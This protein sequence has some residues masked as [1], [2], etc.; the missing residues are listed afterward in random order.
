MATEK[1]TILIIG[2]NA[3]RAIAKTNLRNFARD[4]C[5]ENQKPIPGYLQDN[6]QNALPLGLILQD[7]SFDA[8]SINVIEAKSYE[9]A[10]NIPCNIRVN[11]VKSP[12]KVGTIYFEEMVTF[13]AKTLSEENRAIQEKFLR[14]ALT[15]KPTTSPPAWYEKSPRSLLLGILFFTITVGLFITFA[16]TGLLF[17]PFI[18]I[19]MVFFVLTIG[20]S[21]IA[22]IKILNDNR[23]S[24]STHVNTQPLSTSTTPSETTEEPL[25]D[26]PS[27]RSSGH[28]QKPSSASSNQ[29][30]QKLWGGTE[31]LN[32][33][34]LLVREGTRGTNTY[35]YLE[36]YIDS[37]DKTKPPVWETILNAKTNKISKAVYPFIHS[38][39]VEQIPELGIGFTTLLDE[40]KNQRQLRIPIC[41]QN[42]P[43]IKEMIDKNYCDAFMQNGEQTPFT[44]LVL[45]KLNE[46]LITIPPEL[47]D[48][49]CTKPLGQGM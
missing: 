48:S 11:A 34:K 35:G 27:H 15:I 19:P 28:V 16:L 12:K 21:V 44:R 38:T 7:F 41:T 20:A 43:F 39:T 49:E 4:Y 32:F 5:A 10:K 1:I 30:P 6:S 26:D 47:L 3:A 31:K 22:G 24:Q 45:K 40:E 33:G 8:Y 9:D 25:A 36:N 37:Q 46:A 29:S 18:A 42:V 17:T 14:A 2:E 23:S 13:N